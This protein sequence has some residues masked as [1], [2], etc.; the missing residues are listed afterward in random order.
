MCN[1]W[2][3]I[4]RPTITFK[5]NHMWIFCRLGNWR[6]FLSPIVLRLFQPNRTHLFPIGDVRCWC[7]FL[8]TPTRLSFVD[9]WDETNRWELGPPCEG[10]YLTFWCLVN[11]K[12]IKFS[13][14]HGLVLWLRRKYCLIV[15]LGYMRKDI[16]QV[17]QLLYDCIHM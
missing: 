8:S 9:L 5:A 2:S 13:V 16:F 4:S 6:T 14:D 7:Q 11:N 15:I 17:I 3:M 12:T 10:W 1:R